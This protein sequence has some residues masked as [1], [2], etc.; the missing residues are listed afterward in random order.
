MAATAPTRYLPIAGGLAAGLAVLALVFTS[1]AEAL[2]S[3]VRQTGIAALVPAANPPLGSTARLLLALVGGGCAAAIVWSALF[4]LWGTGGLLAPRVRRSDEDLPEIRRADAHP[5]APPRRPLNAAELEVPVVP[6]PPPEERT[7]PE[8]LDQP[9]AAFDPSA[10]L[11]VP[12]EPVR[13]LSPAGSVGS[14]IRMD[15]PGEVAT[16]PSAEE[17]E[18]I[19]TFAVT[20]IRRVEEDA[21]P[22]PI[23][24]EPRIDDDAEPPSIDSLLDRL[25]RG[26]LRRGRSIN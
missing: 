17:I 25:E 8:D 19:E 3:W 26:T 13:P 23:A 20:P 16:F 4:L 5:D 14:T 24:A 22:M 11:A 7:L 12:R 1:P 21:S 10:I 15:P 9:L 18:R 2:E 6:A